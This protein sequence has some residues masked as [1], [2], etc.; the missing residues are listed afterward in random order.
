MEGNDGCDVLKGRASH[1]AVSQ[2]LSRRG[3]CGKSKFQKN[4]SPGTREE[5][6]RSLFQNAIQGVF[7]STQDGRFVIANP[8]CASIL[9]HASP[10]EFTGGKGK[11]LKRF[12]ADP[13]AFERLQFLLSDTGVVPKFETEVVRPDKKRIWISLKIAA[14]THGNG[15]APSYQGWIEDITEQKKAEERAH[16]LSFHDALT[17]VYNRAYFEEEVKRLDTARQLPISLI[18]GDMN[19]LKIINDGF[20]HEEGDKRLR[21]ISGILRQSCRKEDVIARLGGDEFS[22]FL[23]RTG[24]KSADEVMERIKYLCKAK[25][26]G[27]VDLSIALGAGTKEEPSQDLQDIFRKAEERMYKNK[28]SE[29]KALRNS[30][31][32]SM[33]RILLE[34]SCETEAHFERLKRAV[35]RVGRSLNLPGDE[36]DRLVLLSAWHDVGNIALPSEILKKNRTLAAEEWNEI[37]RH[38][39]IGYRIAESCRELAPISEAILGHHE[40][41]D[42]TGY[43]LNWKGHEIPLISRIF[44]IAD[45][46]DLMTHG[47]IYKSPLERQAVLQELKGGAGRQFDPELVKIFVRDISKI[48]QSAIVPKF[49]AKEF[50][51]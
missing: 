25:S 33:R 34:K 38:P 32:A 35:L 29:S 8:A 37:R 22:V 9:G 4:P 12:F 47:R 28:L 20:G 44:S 30:S 36:I 41:W 31:I 7:Q 39:E 49:V 18:V 27:P 26:T 43:P 1:N 40:R 11:S 23:P 17:G 50:R 6:Y 45:A 48:K 15:V 14:V 3:R 13:A 10:E 2:K 24:A 42:G 46:Y 5:R 51:Q 19:S 16:Y 21:E